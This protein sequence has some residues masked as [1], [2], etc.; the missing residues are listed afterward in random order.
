VN[1]Q[2]FQAFL[3]LRWR[4]RVNQFRR[5]GTA[6]A[7]IL[8]ILSVGA[9]L[10]A[11]VSFVVLFLVGLFA[12]AEVSSTT[13]LYIWD[14]LVVA[15][16]ICWASGVV[17]DVQRSEVLSLEKFLHL[18][19]SP[20]GAFVINY[21]SSLFSLTL[22][23]FLP[24][25]LGLTFGLIGGRGP[26]MLLLLP[27][28]GAFL[29]MVTALTYQFQGWLA[30]LMVNQRRR[31]TI[32]VIMTAIFILI[33]QLP[34]LLN[35]FQPWQGH[36]QSDLIVRQSQEQA[37]LQRQLAAQEITFE[38]YHQRSEEIQREYNA[39]TEEANRQN[40]QQA[41]Q[42]A[43]I[44]NLCLPPGWLPLGVMGL[45]DGTVLPALLAILGLSTLG[46]ASLWRSYRTTLRLYTG[47]F[48]SGQTRT[49]TA[50]VPSVPSKTPPRFLERELPWL[51]EH[52]SA[53]AVSSFRSLSRAPEAK[54]MLL[55]PIILVIVF[56]GMFLRNPT[57]LPENLRPLLA[58]GATAMIL[59]S[60]VQLV[61][62]QFGFDR[63]G[64][65]VFVLCGASRK[66]ILL[67]KNVAVA[68]LILGLS[69]IL[70][71]FLQVMSPMRFDDLLAVVPQML[72]MY[73]LFCLLANMLSILAPIPIAA[74]SFKMSNV[75]GIPLLC[76]LAFMFLFPLALSPTLL[77]L[78]VELIVE[79]S[80]I[81][82]RAP[83]NLV[84][85]VAESV[86]VVYLYRFFLKLEGDLLQSREKRILE[87]VTTK[88]E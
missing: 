67:G 78:G 84:L 26:L 77:P 18:P 40:W 22:L 61:G 37:E 44:V 64:F 48:T 72:S 15:F 79:S 12:L 9:A 76:H 2:H 55:T 58:F 19:V 33:F 17:A 46:A 42:T 75:K 81:I 3:W 5:A 25:M 70:V 39:R 20:T 50:P 52:A 21:V 62:N 86:G 35:L 54:M 69:A 16:L 14:G 8:A 65:R 45:A 68:P 13:L 66:D 49:V 24:A 57:S 87:L 29:L 59:F 82:E 83:F 51:S 30:S 28:L 27:L 38:Q 74:G 71:A 63:N 56:G 4:L 6:N 88:A 85:A 43:K 23:V 32:I 36:E 41:E 47:Q 80:G 53:I 60:M 31:R 34:N 73:L 11:V 10:L 1:W 7:V